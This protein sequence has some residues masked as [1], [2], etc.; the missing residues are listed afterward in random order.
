[1]GREGGGRGRGEEWEGAGEQR[2]RGGGGGGWRGEE[3]GGKGLEGGKGGGCPG[4][5]EALRHPPYP[6]Q[7]ELRPLHVNPAGAQSGGRD[8]A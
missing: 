3:E 2:R 6:R 1:M 7:R 5:G 4:G 8:R